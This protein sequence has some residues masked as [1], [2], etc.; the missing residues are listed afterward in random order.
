MEFKNWYYLQEVIDARDDSVIQNQLSKN[1]D[2]ETIKSIDDL[3]DKYRNDPQPFTIKDI[4]KVVTQEFP[5]ADDKTSKLEKI[6]RDYQRRPNVT[7]E[8]IETLKYFFNQNVN[9][10]Q[11][12]EMMKL[13]RQFLEKDIISLKIENGKPTLSARNQQGAL[14][15]KDTPDFTRFI[16]VLHGIQ[17]SLEKLGPPSKYYDPRTTYDDD[18]LVAKGDNIWVYKGHS[19]ELCRKFGKGII[20]CIASSSSTQN[21]WSY[22]MNHGQTQYFIFDLNK[23]EDD[24]ARY[25]NPG[26]APDGEYSEWVDRKNQHSQDPE[27]TTSDFGINGY[28]SINDYKRYLASKGINPSIFVAE[29]IQDWERRLKDY[30]NR[31]DISGARN[32]VESAKIFPS[33]LK[34]TEEIEDDQF[35][36]LTDNEK[37]I[38]VLR[39]MHTKHQIDWALTYN[40][41]DYLKSFDFITG[42]SDREL[43]DFLRYATDKEFAIDLVLRHKK[44]LTP[45]NVYSILKFSPNLEETEKKLKETNLEKINQLDDEHVS[46]LLDDAKD[47]A[48]AIDLVLKYYKK[49]LY[50]WN[51]SSILQYSPN[52]QE[53]AEKLGETNLQ[54][55][56]RFDDYQVSYL[57]GKAKDQAGAIDFFIK[58]K[59]ELTPK[60]ILNILKY[61]PNLEETAEK[62]GE[63]NLQKINQWSNDIVFD[64]LYYAK[65]QTGTI[66]FFIK[67]KKDLT[68]INVFYILSFSP[69]VEETEKKLKETDLQ[70]INQFDDDEVSSL[71][72][73]ATDQAGIRSLVSKYRQGAE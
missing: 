60:N 7:P 63:T 51:V 45:N 8:E 52:V 55:I 5:L 1:Y 48:G 64:L 38:Y 66:D 10:E 43:G 50:P 58:Y 47:K 69:D 71:I 15:K 29:P 26:V 3:L 65:D 31:K 18:N 23:D 11:L 72:R 37:K 46:D 30:L 56:N 61:S 32:D 62:L 24:P 36:L 13:L 44:K 14:E 21:Y 57:I 22:R 41:Q 49:E 35:D 54:K 20:W 34:L 19:P 4:M 9:S 39:K 53:T 40:R 16:G 68:P 42:L 25:V 73:D 67:Y 70:K 27:I 6:V 2:Q 33:F 59:K 28:N 12:D 17:G